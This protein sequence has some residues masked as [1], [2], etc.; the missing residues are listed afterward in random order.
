MDNIAD[1]ETVD[2][3]YGCSGNVEMVAILTDDIEAVNVLK[4]SFTCIIN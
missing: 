2:I 3:L 4:D 1:A